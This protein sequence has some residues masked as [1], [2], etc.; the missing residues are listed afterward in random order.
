MANQ[1]WALLNGAIGWTAKERRV[2]YFFI[3]FFLFMA[4]P[5]AYGNSQARG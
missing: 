3:L 5:A 4:A 1:C 2:F